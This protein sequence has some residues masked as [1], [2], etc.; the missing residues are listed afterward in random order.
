MSNTKL[1]S[2][3]LKGIGQAKV[4]ALRT[5]HITTVEA[6]ATF[7]PSVASAI[8]VT[9]NDAKNG[10]AALTTVGSW[11]EKAK[12]FVANKEREKTQREQQARADE[13]ERA[14]AARAVAPAPAPVPA[15]PSR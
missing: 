12:Q 13:A 15:A 6:L 11:I 14:R 3:T 2:S 4:D 8:A 7:R 5:H 1:T 9:G 10:K